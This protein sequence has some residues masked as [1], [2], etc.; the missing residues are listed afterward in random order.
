MEVTFAS[1]LETLG[2][3]LAAKRRAQGAPRPCGTS[4]SGVAGADCSLLLQSHP[5]C[6]GSAHS[7]D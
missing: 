6:P 3:R 2:E 5:L 4:T 7:D 1:G